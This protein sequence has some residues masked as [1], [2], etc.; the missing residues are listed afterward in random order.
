MQSKLA[1]ECSLLTYLELVIQ[2]QELLILCF[3]E[4]EN[5]HLA[6]ILKL[7]Y[8]FDYIGCNVDFTLFTISYFQQ[9]L[10]HFDFAIH[11]TLPSS[12]VKVRITPKLFLGSIYPLNY[13]IWSNLPLNKIYIFYLSLHK[14]SLV[15]NFCRMIEDIITYF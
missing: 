13:A 5:S 2:C 11:D 12:I 7:A 8:S 14:R 10:V 3:H 9:L 15:L 1:I 6:T 4:Q